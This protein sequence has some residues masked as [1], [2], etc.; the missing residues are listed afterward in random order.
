[1]YAV[2]PKG[3]WSKKGHFKNKIVTN[4][5]IR[6]FIPMN[7]HTAMISYTDGK[8]A[9]Y[10]LKQPEDKVQEMV[11]KLVREWFP[12]LPDPIFFKI[13]K[14]REGCTYWLPGE[15]DVEEESNKSLQPF[16]KIPLFFTGESF[17]ES[18]CWIES[19]LHQT[20]KLLHLPAFRIRT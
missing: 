1:M 7:N 3:N 12:D 5:R 9:E 19:A 14:W 13:H 6:Y 11:M 10:W 2:F 15:Y 18:Q 4:N 8:D 17:S 20:E 16:P